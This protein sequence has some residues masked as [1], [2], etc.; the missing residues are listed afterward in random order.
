MSLPKTNNIYKPPIK[1][2]PHCGCGYYYQMYKSITCVYCNYSYDSEDA[3]DLDPHNGVSIT[4]D[5][6]VYC[7]GCKE[8]VFLVD[9]EQ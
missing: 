3:C 4:V 6:T 5:P 7:S 2:C 9:E 1:K 8:P